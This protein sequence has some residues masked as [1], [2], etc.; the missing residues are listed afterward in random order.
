MLRRLLDRIYS[1]KVLDA[2]INLAWLSF[3]A[4]PQHQQKTWATFAIQTLVTH[5]VIKMG[6]AV[7]S[8]A[9]WREDGGS[10]A[11]LA[12]ALVKVGLEAS[13]LVDEVSRLVV[14]QEVNWRGLLA[15]VTASLALPECE[16]EWWELI[17]DLVKQGSEDEEGKSGSL[18]AG[19]LLARQ[20]SGPG[21]QYPSYVAWFGATFAEETS[22]LAQQPQHLVSLLTKLL[23]FEPAAII[24][25]HQLAQLDD[26]KALARARLQ[27]LGETAVQ[28]VQPPSA[29]A[30]E[31]ALAAV[32][33]WTETARLPRALTDCFMWQQE[34]WTGR[35]LPAILTCC[36][37]TLALVQGRETLVEALHSKGKVPGSLYSRYKAGTLFER[38][39]NKGNPA[40]NEENDNLEKLELIL[41]DVELLKDCELRKVL[42]KTKHLVRKLRVK[43]R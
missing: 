28:P 30:L 19:L 6:D 26:Y 24:R 35:L 2:P 14:R 12:S 22:T 34:V 25:A 17:S 16:K 10:L 13:E 38:E 20:V 39:E 7:A 43:E 27:E 36:P 37:D 9:E 5:G 41:G 40:E 21:S 4:L 3:P 11:E 29:Q 32:K 31:E 42:E 8:Q 33:E 1:G 23:T 18:L 15:L